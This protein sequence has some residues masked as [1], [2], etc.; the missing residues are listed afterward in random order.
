MRKSNIDETEAAPPIFEI[1]HNQLEG[2]MQQVSTVAHT[3]EA[4]SNDMSKFATKADFAHIFTWYKPMIDIAGGILYRG[5]KL[6]P[7]NVFVTDPVI[8]EEKLTLL[9]TYLAEIATNGGG[10][11]PGSD[12]IGKLTSIQTTLEAIKDNQTSGITAVD[13]SLQ[14]ILAKVSGTDDKLSQVLAPLTYIAQIVSTLTT[15]SEAVKT[16]NEYWFFQMQHQANIETTLTQ[17]KDAVLKIESVE[18]KIQS[19]EAQVAVAV[20]GIDTLHNDLSEIAPKVAVY[21][22][23]ESTVSQRVLTAAV[24]GRHPT[25]DRYEALATYHAETELGTFDRYTLATHNIG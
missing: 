25:N 11:Q 17:I 1:A 2:V 5:D 9:I 22:T 13:T 19:V 18:E 4:I 14:N 21:R 23:E 15:I 12:V 10:G 24:V 16:S 7:V 8:T 3:V 6:N 20:H